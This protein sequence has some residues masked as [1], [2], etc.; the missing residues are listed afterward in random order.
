LKKLQMYLTFTIQKIQ[1]ELFAGLY[2]LNI[3]AITDPF[4]HESPQTSVRRI[5]CCLG[6][7]IQSFKLTICLLKNL[8]IILLCRKF[9]ELITNYF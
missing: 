2:L 6:S 1:I 8:I 7:K 5:S 9:I 3:K 4:L